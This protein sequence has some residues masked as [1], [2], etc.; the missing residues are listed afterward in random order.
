[1]AADTNNLPVASSV[2]GD[3]AK[4]SPDSHL[5]VEIDKG[6]YQQILDIIKGAKQCVLVSGSAGTGKTTF[7]E[8]LLSAEGRRDLSMAENMGIVAPTGIAAMQAGGA[9]IHSLFQFPPAAYDYESGYFVDG[10]GID[11][12]T[13]KG[14][15]FRHMELLVI[16][17]VSM[18]RADLMD[19]IDRSMRINRRRMDKPFGGVKLLLVGDIFQL[20]P[21]VQRDDH[22]FLS[23]R[24]EGANGMFFFNSMAIR[25]LLAKDLMGAVEL[26][27]ARRF[28][29]LDEKESNF[30]KMLNRIRMGDTQDLEKIN[31]WLARDSH[32]NKLITN[33]AVILTGLRVVA[34]RVNISKLDAL[35][36]QVHLFEGTAEGRCR[37]YA[38]SKLPVP[39]SLE[40]KVGAQI[41]FVR[42]GPDGAWYNGSLAT[43]AE[44]VDDEETDAESIK[45]RML[46]D[47]SVVEVER[48]EWK[49]MDYRYNKQ[50]NRI[51]AEEAGNYS[52]YPFMLAWAMTIHRAQGKTLKSVVID[53][54]R[55]TFSAGQAYVAL[56]RCREA[57]DVGLMSPLLGKDIICHPE[58][59][60]FYQSRLSE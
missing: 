30:Y 5:P 3:S 13:G 8:Y 59:V 16:D 48:E 14:R 60:Q 43:V 49:V 51:E 33:N 46:D 1:M 18:V 27:I 31:H 57:K 35:S 41:I 9:T 37:D 26:K 40:L 6:E 58:V 45:V 24:Y 38:D 11:V 22:E 34:D 32:C 55:G 25:E 15:V 10:E 21:V 53:L 28:I 47:D 19:A 23:A 12:L 56:S 29:N 52:Q 54:K 17:E 39:K 42:N 7:I 50:E 4:D 36:G 2:T 44:F 20:Q